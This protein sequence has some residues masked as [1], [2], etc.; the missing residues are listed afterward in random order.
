MLAFNKSKIFTEKWM[1]SRNILDTEPKG[2]GDRLD[3]KYKRKGRDKY[4]SKIFGL[5]SNNNKKK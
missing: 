4:E 3:V 5:S 2:F 1:D